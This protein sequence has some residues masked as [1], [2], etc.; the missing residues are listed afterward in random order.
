MVGRHH[1]CCR[2]PSPSSSSS[3]S[4][5]PV[6]IV[7]VWLV[8][9]FSARP[10]SREESLAR[11]LQGVSRGVSREESNESLVRSDDGWLA[12]RTYYNKYNKFCLSTIP[13]TLESS[14]LSVN[15]S[16]W[17]CDGEIDG[18]ICWNQPDRRTENGDRNKGFSAFGGN[19]PKGI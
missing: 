9:A 12:R 11:S 6:T 10:I 14:C 17:N 19:P 15:N 7:V 1:R 13:C 4:S 18:Y 8:V 2:R 3:P 5:S 16:R